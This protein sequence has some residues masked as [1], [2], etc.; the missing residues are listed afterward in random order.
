MSDRTLPGIETIPVQHCWISGRGVVLTMR[1]RA[2]RLRHWRWLME[3][4]GL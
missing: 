2:L 3:R 4:L 1:S